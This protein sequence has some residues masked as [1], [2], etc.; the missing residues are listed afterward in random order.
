[1]ETGGPDFA[2][3]AKAAGVRVV[4]CC[5]FDSIPHDLGAYFTMREL[6]PQSRVKVEGF[7][8]AGG[9]EGTVDRLL[10]NH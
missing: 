6:K 2:K 4:S 3:R 10:T 7:I 5:G 1:M 8:Q 9:D